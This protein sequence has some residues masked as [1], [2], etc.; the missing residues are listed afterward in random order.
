MTAAA[1]VNG[2][3]VSFNL[4]HGMH[5]SGFFSILPNWGCGV[6]DDPADMDYRQKGQRI[7]VVF[8]DFFKN[9]NGCVETTVQS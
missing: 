3:Q 7:T 4:V 6:N 2:V 8:V 5:L 1:G 9:K